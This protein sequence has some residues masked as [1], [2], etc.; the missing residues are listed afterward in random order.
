MVPMY[1]FFNNTASVAPYCMPAS[2]LRRANLRLAFVSALQ[3]CGFQVCRLS[4]V[5]PRYV[6][7]SICWSSV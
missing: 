5:T 6:A 3:M 4:K 7:L 1:T 2:F